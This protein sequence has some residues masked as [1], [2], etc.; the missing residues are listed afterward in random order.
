MILRYR[1]KNG[2]HQEFEVG[3]RP[4][5]IGRG[6]NSDLVLLDDQAS[7]IHCGIRLWD[8]E[9]FIKDMKSRNGTFVNGERVEMA[10]LSAGDRIRIG[11]TLFGF[12]THPAKGTETLLQEVA[13]ELS[14]GKGYTTLLREII[15]DSD[16]PASS[17][18]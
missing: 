18:T 6:A 16:S 12:E 7:R 5:T 11:R 15:E 17:E 8:G 3:D 4:I 9:F 10:R 14:E 2:V 1:G 13:D